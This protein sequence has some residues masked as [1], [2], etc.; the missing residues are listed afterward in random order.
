MFTRNHSEL[1]HNKITQ[2]PTDIFNKLRALRRLKLIGSKITCDCETHAKYKHWRSL[3]LDVELTCHGPAKIGGR[4]IAQLNERDVNCSKYDVNITLWV[5]CYDYDSSWLF[6]SENWKL[7]LL[8]TDKA[9]HSR[10]ANAQIEEVPVVTEGSNLFICKSDE[11]L[12]LDDGAFKSYEDVSDVSAGEVFCT[13]STTSGGIKG[14]PARVEVVDE[15]NTLMVKIFAKHKSAI[16][17][18]NDE[19]VILQCP[20]GLWTRTLLSKIA[21]INCVIHFQKLH[22]AWENFSDNNRSNRNSCSNRTILMHMRGL[23]SNWPV[24]VKMIH[25]QRYDFLG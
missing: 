21:Q 2:I 8:S 15:N 23:P 6:G 19:Q 25:H 9:E 16:T 4:K 11:N 22:C 1:D 7:H 12:N 13:I 17:L 18:K 20:G 5:K 10:D 24:K 14:K 3:G